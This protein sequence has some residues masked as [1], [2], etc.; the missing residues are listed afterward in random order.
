MIAADSIEGKPKALNLEEGLALT[1]L[2]DNEVVNIFVELD[3]VIAPV[4]CI[5][6]DKLELWI[7]LVDLHRDCVCSFQKVEFS[8]R[9]LEVM[10]A[11]VELSGNWNLFKRVVGIERVSCRVRVQLDASLHYDPLLMTALRLLGYTNLEH[12]V[13]LRVGQ[14]Q[15]VLLFDHPINYMLYLCEGQAELYQCLFFNPAI[16]LLGQLDIR[17]V[18]K[19]DLERVAVEEVSPNEAARHNIPRHGCR[20]QTNAILMCL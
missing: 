12:V 11:G 20:L 10:H 2:L 15:R 6:V 16:R 19:L 1:D 13:A 7:S 3:R 4:L 18:L 17:R 5:P 8:E 14:F 9:T